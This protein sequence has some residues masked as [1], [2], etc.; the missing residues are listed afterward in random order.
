MTEP[1]PAPALSVEEAMSRAFAH[2]QAGRFAEAEPLYRAVLSARPDHHPAFH[3]LGVLALQLKRPEVATALIGQALARDATVPDYHL[4][5]G[6]ALREAGRPDAAV[7]CYR[8]ALALDPQQFNAALNLGNALRAQGDAAA[9]AA[10]RQ[11]VT[12][13]PQHDDARLSLGGCLF[14][15][16]RLDEA[17]A[18]FREGARRAP[19]RAAFFGNLG[20]MEQ[21]RGRLAEALDALERAHALAPDAVDIA[22]NLASTLHLLGRSAASEAV[23]RDALAHGSEAGEL[24]GIHAVALLGIGDVEGAVGAYRRALALLPGQAMAW[25]N[26]GVVLQKVPRM[27][28]AGAAHRRALRVAPGEVAF[29]AA[30]G[31]A[32]QEAGCLDEADAVL[33]RTLAL[34]PA[35]PDGLVHLASTRHEQ[36]R[37]G[38]AIALFRRTIFLNPLG[39]SARNGCGNSLLAAARVL[40]AKRHFEQTL[41]L[42]PAHGLAHNNLGGVNRNLGDQARA[43]EHFRRSLYVDGSNA[44]IHSNLLLTL[45]YQQGVPRARL[46]EEHLAWARRYAEPLTAAAPPPANDPDP[47]RPLR[48]GYVSPDF[49]NHAA[50]Y[51]LEPLFENHDHSRFH[52]TGYA[53]VPAPDEVT[54]RLRRHT[55]AWV[56]TVGMGDAELAARIRADRIDVLID[57][58]GHTARNRLTALAHRPAPVQAHYLGYPTTTGMSA[59]DY[60]IIDRWLVPDDSAE[61]SWFTEEIWR[62][63]RVLRCYKGPEHAPPVNPLP[64]AAAGHLTFGS[65]NAFVKVTPEVVALWARI[66]HRVP[67][68]RLLVVANV[69][70]AALHARFAPHGIGP[71]R[72]ELLPRQD[73]AGYFRL[74]HRVDVALDPFPHA[75]GTTT[76]HSLWM[77][78]PVLTLAGRA[79]AER[80]GVGVLGPVGLTD[81]IA[82]TPDT[83]VAIAERCA[84]DLDGLAA[85]RAG[86]RARMEASPLLDGAGFARDLEDACR[87]M[88]RRWCARQRAG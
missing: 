40:E 7:V 35:H 65:L 33:C 10:Y 75:G 4:N 6:V 18:V 31:C 49:R 60:H 15:L 55:D 63:P 37:V 82:T 43:V 81:F 54:E 42:D 69:E 47:D 71:E 29:L 28:E 52:I 14:G 1:S 85:V 23:C 48:I 79:I 11:A 21:K 3:L 57:L 24:H 8:R 19:G 88:W 56:S 73:L 50:A 72:L 26:L 27:A 16:G 78:V 67:D 39:T 74:F 32:L 38:S 68:S 44:A 5:L 80:G 61:P 25:S 34:S 46:K 30:Y 84:A 83:Y 20:L 51:F 9:A 22:V 2:H 53:E 12:L 36:R 77:G 64:A 87:A 76:F 13:M 62:L 17:A 58:G 86:L 59:I 41:A 66:L 45:C 70:P